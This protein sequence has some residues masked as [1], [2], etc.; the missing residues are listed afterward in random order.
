MPF[1]SINSTNPRTN[2]W[3]FHEKILRIGGAGKWGFFE[4]AILNFLSRPFWIFFCFISVKNPALLY[5]VSFFSALW[6]VFP[7]S[8]KRSCPNFYAHDCTGGAAYLVE[9]FTPSIAIVTQLKKLHHFSHLALQTSLQCNCSSNIQIDFMGT[10]QANAKCNNINHVW[11]Q[12]YKILVV[13]KYHRRPWVNIFDTVI[14]RCINTYIKVVYL[15]FFGIF[16]LLQMSV[17][18]ILAQG[19]LWY[20]KTTKIL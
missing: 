14:S 11:S 5:E 18:K 12:F 19:R 2:P 3:K 7:E 6:M 13:L 16:M 15:A 8:W 20:F 10:F 9:L 1:A 4:A 17:S